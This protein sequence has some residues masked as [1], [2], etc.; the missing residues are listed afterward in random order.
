ML[1]I[2]R[3]SRLDCLHPLSRIRKARF[4]YYVL[5]APQRIPSLGIHTLFCR[6]SDYW[7]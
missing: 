6:L 2:D 4:A 3:P 5:Q 7:I 1:A